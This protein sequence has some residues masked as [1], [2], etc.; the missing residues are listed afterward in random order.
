MCTSQ[1]HQCK[2]ALEGVEHVALQRFDTKNVPILRVPILS[3]LHHCFLL[4]LLLK[5]TRS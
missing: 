5:A 3:V 4:P 1:L 2:Y